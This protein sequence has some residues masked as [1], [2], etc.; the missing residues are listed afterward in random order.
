MV[1]LRSE[2][3]WA[4][5]CMEAARP[6]LEVRQFDDNSGAAMH[7]LDLWRWDKRVGACEVTAAAHGDSTQLWK[8]A[9]APKGR[10][11]EDGLQGGWLLTLEMTCRWKILRPALRPFLSSLESRNITRVGHWD[12]PQDVRETARTLGI[13]HA[14]QSST[15][16]LGSVYF[17]L[18]LPSE[19][20]CGI[21]PDDGNTLSSWLSEWINHPDRARKIEKVVRS[22]AQERHLFVILPSFNV[23]P[24]AAADVLRQD[25]G[26]LPITSPELPSGLTHIWTMSTWNS[27][28]VLNWSSGS[29]WCRSE[30]VFEVPRRLTGA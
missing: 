22:K 14:M 30:K 17:T 25:Y 12:D 18:N 27:G 8:L 15:S 11:I 23:A 4:A 28:D 2:E 1:T 19:M 16:F 20:S 6:G 24:F 10:H 13:H 7:D 3:A 9:N 5:A 21:V 26:P 29:G